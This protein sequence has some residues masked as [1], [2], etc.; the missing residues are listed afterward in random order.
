MSENFPVLTTQSHFPKPQKTETASPKPSCSTIRFFQFHIMLPTL[1]N[2]HFKPW[3]LSL[4]L[5]S[6]IIHAHRLGNQREQKVRKKKG[7]AFS[8]IFSPALGV[9]PIHTP[10]SLFEPK[11]SRTH[12]APTPQVMERL[13]FM[14]CIYIYIRAYYKIRFVPGRFWRYVFFGEVL[15]PAHTHRGGFTEKRTGGVFGSVFCSK[16]YESEKPILSNSLNMH[17]DQN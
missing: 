15:T 12:F 3:S 5:K 6:H 14:H 9:P 16:P 17:H 8:S 4:G 10:S 7:S 1:K 13:E 11:T 2:P